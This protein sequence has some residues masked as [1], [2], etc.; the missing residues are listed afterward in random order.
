M[1]AIP[2]AKI[3]SRGKHK[4]S[5]RTLGRGT[6]RVLFFHGFPGSSAQIALFSKIF[7]KLDLSVLALDRPGYNQTA[8]GPD[9][10]LRQAT[11]DAV[12]VLNEL[13][14]QKFEIFCVSGGTPFGLTLANF[15]GARV[16]KINIVCGLPPLAKPSIKQ[17]MV[18]RTILGLR[19]VPLVPGRIVKKILL[20]KQRQSVLNPGKALPQKSRLLQVFLPLSKLDREVMSDTEV[21]ESVNFALAEAFFQNALGPKRDAKTFLRDWGWNLAKLKTPLVFWHGDEDKIIPLK[22]AIAF[23]KSFTNSNLNIVPGEGHYS[24]PIRCVEKILTE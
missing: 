19:A 8:V 13:G 6:R 17:K 9:L 7:E 4:I 10:Q 1:T 22:A 2:A 23:E 16:T 18:R 24:L 20:K 11:D 12:A 21:H 3:F 15:L 5:F 14:W